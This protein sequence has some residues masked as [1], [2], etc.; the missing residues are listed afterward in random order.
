MIIGTGGWPLTIILT[1]DLK[2]FFAGTYFP[3]ESGNRVSGLRDLILNVNDLW[4]N[5]RADLVKSA[6]EL[7]SHYSNYLNFQ[8]GSE[9]KRTS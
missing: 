9:P 2:P 1:P 6:E 7:T 4:E 5:N 8:S 3:K